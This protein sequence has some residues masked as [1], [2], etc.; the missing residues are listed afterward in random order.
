MT[1][2]IAFIIRMR[3]DISGDIR[4]LKGVGLK[5]AALFNKLE[6]SSIEDLLYYFPRRY[7]DRTVITGIGSLVPGECQTVRARIIRVKERPVFRQRGFRIFEAVA[8]DSTGRLSCV[9]FN[10]PYLKN[11]IMIDKEV[12][13][14]GKVGLYGN[15]LQMQN[16]EYEVISSII[17]GAESSEQSNKSL[18]SAR[19]IPVYSLIEGL[20]QRMFRRLIKTCLD[21]HISGIIDILPYDIR[22]RNHL[23]NIASAVLNMHFPQD[24]PLQEEAYKRI[25]FEECFLMQLIFGLKRY[26]ADK[27]IGT[28]HR[29]NEDFLKSFEQGLSFELTNSQKKVIAQIKKDMSSPNPMYR[30]L[31]GDVGCGK[32]IVALYGCMISVSN[33]AQ[34]AFMAPTEIL[35]QQHYKNIKYQISNIKYNNNPINAALLTG[36]LSKKEKEEVYA[37]LKEGNINILVGTHA[38]LQEEVEF[39]N[40][41]LVVIDEQHKFGVYQRMGLLTKGL[42]PDCLIMTATPIPRTLAMTIYSD[43]DISTIDELPSGRIPVKTYLAGEDRRGWVYDF[44]RQSLQSGRQAYIVYPIIDESETLELKSAKVM[45]ED[46]KKNIFSDFKVG[47]VHGRMKQKERDKVMASF[48]K[49]EIDLLVSTVVI[50]VGIDVANASVMVIEHAERFGLSQLHQLRGRI[51]RGAHQ[52]HCILI[53]DAAGDESGQRLRVM[54]EEADGFKI[55]ERDLEIR[56]PGEFFGARQHGI[57]ELRVNPLENMELLHTAKKEADALIKKDPWLGLR[58][59]TGLADT[60]KRRFPDCEKMVEA[61]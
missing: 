11:Y 23:L 35:A 52:S 44:I 55:A 41:S 32:T 45:Y 27:I 4:Y 29:L 39:K 53:S 7:E 22:R 15:S 25:I 40:L 16:P 58:Q 3:K 19:I 56:G 54:V 59:N 13:L 46:L 42:N 31:E 48:R 60:L 21:E 1:R 9:W 61:G 43:L 2:M 17:G 38:L 12:M 34:A 51:G 24:A 10:Q 36:S 57:P 14:F 33:G 6:I 50:E 28:A 18:N 30:L 8:Q 26:K 37:G 5:R 49:G 20:S 47:L